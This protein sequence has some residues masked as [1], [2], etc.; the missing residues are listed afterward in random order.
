[1][2]VVDAADYPLL[3]DA[4]LVLRQ[5]IEAVT[6]Q[7]GRPAGRQGVARKATEGG[8]ALELITS[9]E[10]RVSNRGALR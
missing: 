1:M 4:R 8:Q 9:Q 3:G 7:G 6:E 5:C 10:T 2:K